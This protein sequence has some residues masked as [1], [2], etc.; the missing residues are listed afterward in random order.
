MADANDDHSLALLG[1]KKCKTGY[2][3][4][5]DYRQAD[6]SALNLEHT[7]VS[8]MSKSR[9]RVLPTFEFWIYH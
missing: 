8:A 6:T 2:L 4:H 1:I 7:N 9:V 3:H 5:L